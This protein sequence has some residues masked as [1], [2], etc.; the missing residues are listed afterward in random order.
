MA[1]ARAGVEAWVRRAEGFAY[2]TVIAPL[3][4]W[5]PARLAYRVACWRGDW[6]RRL[7]PQKR[8]EIVRDLRRVLGNEVSGDAAERLARE[9]FRFR[10]ARS[11]T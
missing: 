6:T 1:E 7:W 4:A 9:I 8:A 10:R 3:A 11:W 2:W 5:L